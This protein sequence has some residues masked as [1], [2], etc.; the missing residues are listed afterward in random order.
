M[1]A[2]ICRV[3]TTIILLT[4]RLPGSHPGVTVQK[5]SDPSALPTSF[6][7]PSFHNQHLHL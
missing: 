6:L 2:R 4:G 3:R 7:F 1:E 5:D